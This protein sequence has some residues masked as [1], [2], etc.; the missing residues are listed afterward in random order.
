MGVFAATT[1][2]VGSLTVGDS[3]RGSLTH[4]A[5]D[6][7]GRI[8]E[9]LVADHFASLGDLAE[10]LAAGPDFPTGFS[11]VPAILVPGNLKSTDN[12]RSAAAPNE[13]TIVGCSTIGELGARA[14]A[15]PIPFCPSQIVLNRPLADALAAVK[16]GDEV[17]VEIGRADLI[18]PDS[19][20]GRKTETTRSRRLKV[21][22]VIPAEGLG[23][24]GLRPDSAICRCKTLSWPAQLWPACSNSLAKSTR[25]SSPGPRAGSPPR[26]S[27]SSSIAI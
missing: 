2:L 12:R 15:H 14:K 3:V 5:L 19:S 26:S 16:S 1:V 25:Y 24:V 7:L 4:L 27:M 21:S 17:L 22:A 6:R 10:R 18:P 23:R 11:A 9:I 8:D 20:L 13:V